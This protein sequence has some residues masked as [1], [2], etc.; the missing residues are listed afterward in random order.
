MRRQRPRHKSLAVLM[1][2]ILCSLGACL[3]VGLWF[4]SALTQRE[5]VGVATL[6]AGAARMELSG[7]DVVALPPAGTWLKRAYR[8]GVFQQGGDALDRL[9]ARRGWEHTDQEGSERRYS[10][11]GQTLS[12]DCGMYSIHYQ[13]CRARGPW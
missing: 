2:G 5:P 6:I 7:A 1:V 8:R 11:G 9:L 12:V 3:S 13:V 4:G 10:R